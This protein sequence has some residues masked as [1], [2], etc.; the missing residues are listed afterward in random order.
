MHVKTILLRSLSSRQLL[1]ENAHRAAKYK[2]LSFTLSKQREAKM[3]KVLVVGATGF[4]GGLIAKQAAEAGHQVTALVSESSQSSKKQV[5]D[6]L[7]AAGVTIVTGSLESDHKDLVTVMK[8]VDAVRA[9]CM[10]LCVIASHNWIDVISTLKTG[11][12]GEL[13]T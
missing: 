3:V 2:L 12:D 13:S 10:L 7:K 11:C 1:L 8:T 9:R 4:L 5:V 6:G